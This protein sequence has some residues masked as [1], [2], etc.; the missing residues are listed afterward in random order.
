MIRLLW[1]GASHAH[2]ERGHGTKHQALIHSIAELTGVPGLASPLLVI[3]WPAR[4]SHDFRYSPSTL[5]PLM[6]EQK[7]RA[8]QQRPR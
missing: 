7:R 8:I 6:I 5:H 2:A 3:L 1:A 4:K